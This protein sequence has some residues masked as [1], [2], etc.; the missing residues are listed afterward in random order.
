MERES[1][2]ADEVSEEHHPLVEFQSRNNLTRIG[3]RCAMSVAKYL[4][5]R[6]FVVSSSET[7]EAIHLPP[8][9][10]MFGMVVRRR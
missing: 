4:A 8:A 6:S 9:P 2:S 1:Q 3:S 10:D 5:S 7:E